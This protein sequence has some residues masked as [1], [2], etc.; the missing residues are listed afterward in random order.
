MDRAGVGPR[1]ARGRGNDARPA[2]SRARFL[3][4]ISRTFGIRRTLRAARRLGGITGVVCGLDKLLFGAASR[5]WI[6]GAGHPV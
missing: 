1:R 2:L 5:P 4:S 6:A 3:W